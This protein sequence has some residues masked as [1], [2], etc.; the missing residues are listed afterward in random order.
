MLKRPLP[1][2]ENCA[3]TCD[4]LG[5]IAIQEIGYVLMNPLSPGA[6]GSLVTGTVAP[7]KSGA[8]EVVE[9]LPSKVSVG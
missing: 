9:E 3:F 8:R 1:P 4:V 6:P 7:G 2:V 5:D